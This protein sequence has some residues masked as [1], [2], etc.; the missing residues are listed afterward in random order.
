M[1]KAMTFSKGDRV[2]GG[3]ESYGSVIR[4][5]ATDV[6]VRWDRSGFVGRVPYSALHKVRASTRGGEVSDQQRQVLIHLRDKGPYLVQ[7]PGNV[8]T[9]AAKLPS[10]DFLEL[11]TERLTWWANRRTV[12]A[13]ERR[14]LIET[15]VE[16]WSAKDDS[17]PLKLTPA[18]LQL[19]QSI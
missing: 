6:W 8:W 2:Q 16:Y 11:S 9:S 1:E 3:G 19:A 5:S 4:C 7:Y 12:L 18:G 17:R 13:L 10:S 15:A 14:G